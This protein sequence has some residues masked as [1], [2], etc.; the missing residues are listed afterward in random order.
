MYNIEDV[1]ATEEISIRLVPDRSDNGYYDIPSRFIFR[2]FRN[3]ITNK[4]LSSDDFEN[5][6]EKS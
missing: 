3:I 6:F 4:D 2:V 1:P 5:I